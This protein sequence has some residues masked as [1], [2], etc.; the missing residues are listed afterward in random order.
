MFFVCLV[1]NEVYI[2]CCNTQKKEQ[3]GHKCRPDVS[4]CAEQ[5]KKKK[6]P[7]IIFLLTINVSPTKIYNG[8]YFV[9]VFGKNPRVYACCC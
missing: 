7:K 5:K 9:V 6:S 1:L 4:D 3:G 8:R 2:A